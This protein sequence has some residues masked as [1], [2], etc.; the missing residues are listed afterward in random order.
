MRL[1]T[2]AISCA[3]IPILVIFAHLRWREE[4]RPELPSWRNGAAL[5][6]MFIVLSLWLIQTARW[7]FLS[8][9]HHFTGL[10]GADW[11]EIETFLPAYYAYP[12][13]PLAFASKGIPRLL[14]IAAWLSLACFY[15]DF[16]Y[17]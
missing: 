6:S 7:V 9:N 10:L 3:A 2:P 5:A 8:L 13:L 16:W 1:I 17:E 15:R 4:I 11:R 14:M 12:A